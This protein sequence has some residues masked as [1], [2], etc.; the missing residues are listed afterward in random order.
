MASEIFQVVSQ[1]STKWLSRLSKITETNYYNYYKKFHVSCVTF[2]VSH[3]TCHMSSVTCHMPCVT[4][5]VSPVPCHL[6][7]T[8]TAI[9]NNPPPANSPIMLVRK[10]PKTKKKGYFF[11]FFYL[12]TKTQQCLDVSQYQRLRPL[13]TSLQSTGRRL[14]RDS[15]NTH[16]HDI[17]TSRLRD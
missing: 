15:T 11:Y 9:A 6:S 14:F 2:R 7:L 10:D 12:K 1:G 16:T 4:F 8:L 5:H 17:R 3:V 13:T